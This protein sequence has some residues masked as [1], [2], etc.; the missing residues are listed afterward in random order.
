MVDDSFPGWCG[1]NSLAVYTHALTTAGYS[2]VTTWVTET[3]GTPSA[4]AMQ[5]KTVVWYTGK[6]GY[7]YY[8]AY[9]D[10][11]YTPPTAMITLASAERAEVQTFL[12]PAVTCSSPAVSSATT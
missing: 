1:E 10:A 2:N 11:G 8:F 5:G 4:A 7:E 3:S 9:Y 12:T 6:A